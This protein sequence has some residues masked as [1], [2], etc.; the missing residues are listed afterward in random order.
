MRPTVVFAAILVLIGV[1]VGADQLLAP[2]EV[3][4]VETRT[5]GPS[6]AGASYCAVGDTAQGNGLSLI[7]AAP[8]VGPRSAETRIDLLSEGRV[9]RGPEVEVFPSTATAAEVPGGQEGIAAVARWWRNPAVVTRVWDVNAAGVPNG[10]VEGPCPAT[11][12]RRWIVPG[13]TT[14]GGA[15]AHLVLAN[16]FETDATLSVSLLTPD[17]PVQ[18]ILLE[19][20]VVPRRAVRTI[21][22]NEHRPEELDVGLVVETRAGRVVAEAYQVLDAA[23]GGVEGITLVPAT[24]EP[25]ETWTAPWFQDDTPPRAPL[26]VEAATPEA[27]EPPTPEQEP[28]AEEPPPPQSQVEAAEP[29]ARSWIWVANPSDRPAAVTVTLH[30]VD[31]GVT[32]DGLEELT[33]PPGST[34]RIDLAGLLPEGPRRGGWTV[35]S[36]NGVP[37]VAASAT[38]IAAD[39][40]ERTGI[41]VTSAAPQADTMWVLSGHAAPDRGAFV[42]LLNPTS[43]AATIDIEL[44]GGLGLVEAPELTGISVPAGSVTAVDIGAH[45]PSDATGAT[46]FVV[47]TE[48]R[49]IA[50]R[51]ALQSDG[52]L[53]LTAALGVPSQRWSGGREVRPVRFEPGLSRRIGTDSGPAL[54]P[55]LVPTEQESPAS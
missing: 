53:D 48:G 45:L 35:R 54:E 32:P 40:V 43:E 44:W 33:I 21:L 36:E 50:A 11:P 47:A 31:G 14:A 51:Q 1:G 46:A 22:V 49:V 30:T 55:A 12:S 34:S 10:V 18:P 37:V 9:E 20:V 52:Q 16:P 24:A 19:N 6:T 38:R 15:T 23:V 7:T 13:M 41:A 2:V 5:T 3:G 29:G 39:A 4:P 42:H 17:G 8:S 27:T 25:A 28:T 26:P